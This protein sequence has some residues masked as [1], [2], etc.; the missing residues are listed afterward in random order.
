MSWMLA[1]TAVSVGVGYMSSVSSA[2]GQIRASNAVSRAE[3]EA[4]RKERLNMSIRNS[5][6]TAL[7]QMNLGLKKR[8]LSQQGADISAAGLTATA[9]AQVANAATGSVGATTNAVL[10][11]IDQK[12]QFAKDQTTDQF[13]N[14]VENYNLDLKMMV[15]NTEQSAPTMRPNVDAGPSSGQMLAGAVLSGIGQFASTYA[16]RKMQLGLGDRPTNAQIPSPTSGY[17][18]N[19]R[20]WQGGGPGV[21]LGRW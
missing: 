21:Q 3:G 10:S 11:D 2:N 6:S 4:I 7:A 15:I 9:D 12:V 5:Y 17:G 18:I 20:T 14:A 8:Q 16:M 1:A 13:E 19:L